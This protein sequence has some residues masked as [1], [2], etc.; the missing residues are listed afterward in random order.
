[1]QTGPTGRK[2][3]NGKLVTID[4]EKHRAYENE[5]NRI[6][7]LN[8]KFRNHLR[9]YGR[10]YR[11]EKYHYYRGLILEMFNN[12]CVKC[13]FD[14]VKALQ[15][16]HVNDDGYNDRKKYGTTWRYFKKIYKELKNGSKDYQVLCAN[17]NQIK[18]FNH[19]SSLRK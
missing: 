13:G 11:T 16:D 4:F 14:N 5:R 17:C 6:R 3:I 12:K 19:R 15:V 2:R 1:M 7:K 18:K 9:K 8:P 10:K